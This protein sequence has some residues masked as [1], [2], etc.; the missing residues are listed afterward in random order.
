MTRLGLHLMS[1]R[2]GAQA[3]D[4]IRQVQPGVCKILDGDRGLIEQARAVSPNTTWIG[5]VVW[6]PQT[7]DAYGDFQKRVLSKAREHQGLIAAWE[8]Y[9]EVGWKGE[10]LRKF[11]GLEVGLAKRLND[12][13]FTA[14]IGG[15][16]TGFLETAKDFDYF[17]QALEYC[18]QNP[19]R[20][21]LH[22]HEY[23]APYVQYMVRTPDGRNQW[24]HAGASWTGFSD[25]RSIYYDAK[26]D[27]WLTLR[28]RM[29]RWKLEAEGLGNVR[30]VITESGIDG[31][32][33]PR[34]GPQG[35]GFRDFNTAD[36]RR[37]VGDY[38][39]Q[40]RWYL[41]QM[42]HDPYVVGAV[43]F[44]FGTIDPKW[45]TFDLAQDA[46]MLAR[47]V[48]EM[49]ALPVGQI[50]DPIPVPVPVPT[51]TPTPVPVP[52]PV[53]G[54]EA[55]VQVKQGDGWM[56]VVRRCGM[57]ASPTT[58]AALKAANPG[59]TALDPGMWLASPWHKVVPKG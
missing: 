19:T 21:W 57:T 35:G 29:L 44:G 27:G 59:V 34:P 36:W 22:F 28:Y 3:I 43:D 53:G 14:C 37:V 9:N 47:M 23:A 13:G 12:A 33:V 52:V 40:M 30:F 5:R 50:T 51:P 2:A 25:A 41:W 1:N 20:A 16:S 18:H 6:D 46:G 8:G 10:D 4:Y 15:F 26:V 58:V 39:D 11:A 31:G 42:S 48:A 56:A 55:R 54:P 32:V 17:R 45:N 24:N 49:Q 7:F 38:A